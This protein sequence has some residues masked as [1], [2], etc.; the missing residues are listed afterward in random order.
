VAR[1]KYPEDLSQDMKDRLARLGS[2]NI[3]RM[4]AHSEPVLEGYSRM[5]LTL[6]RKGKLD[7]RLREIAVLKIGL[8]CGSDYEWHQHVSLARAVGVPEATIEAIAGNRHAGLPETERFVIDFAEEIYRLKRPTDAVFEAMRER[9]STEALV[10]LTLTC[11][12]YIMTACFLRTFDIEI[13]DGPSLGETIAR[14]KA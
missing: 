11:G 6:L 12:Y 8:L 3:T 1:T 10:E 4:M 2:L 14:S 13:E 5:G 9:L 7:P